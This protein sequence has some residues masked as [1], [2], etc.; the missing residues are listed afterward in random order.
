ML[1]RI[2]DISFVHDRKNIIDA[3]FVVTWLK[4]KFD[5]CD[6]KIIHKNSLPAIIAVAIK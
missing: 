6:K 4:E 2:K 5:G 1:N 3:T